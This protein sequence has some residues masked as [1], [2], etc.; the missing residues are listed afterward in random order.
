MIKPTRSSRS[1]NKFSITYPYQGS[2]RGA[3]MEE[4]DITNEF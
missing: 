2:V 1:I 4:H 3:L